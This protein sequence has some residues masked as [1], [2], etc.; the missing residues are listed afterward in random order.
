MCINY[1]IST[2]PIIITSTVHWGPGP[3]NEQTAVLTSTCLQKEVKDHAARLGMI[4]GQ[5]IKSPVDCYLSRPGL[6]LLK[7]LTMW[8]P[9]LG[10][11]CAMQ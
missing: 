4:C 7:F 2:F 9:N 5:D 6:Q 10:L 8:G 1:I 3:T 11:S